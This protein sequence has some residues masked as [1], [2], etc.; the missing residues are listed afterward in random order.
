MT[1]QQALRKAIEIAGNQSRLH[2][3]IG[4]KFP[5]NIQWWVVKGKVPAEW[6]KRIEAATGVPATELR[7]DIFGTANSAVTNAACISPKRTTT[8]QG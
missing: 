5:Q 6:V 8:L 3:A 1:P 7:P 4:T 2:R